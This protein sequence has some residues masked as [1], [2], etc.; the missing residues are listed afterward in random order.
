MKDQNVT[1]HTISAQ[2]YSVGGT[3]FISA[4]RQ[5]NFRDLEVKDNANNSTI[6]LSG[7]TSGVSGGDIS[8]TGTLST[9]TIS[10]KTS[11]S[12]VTIDS[13]LLKDGDISAGSLTLTGDLSISGTTTTINSTTVAVADSMFKYAKDNT[14]NN[15][16]IGFY[17]Q[18]V[19]SSTTKYSG[20]YYSASDSK[21]HIFKDQQA[22]PTTTVNTSGTGYTKGDLV[23]GNIDITTL[24][25]NSSTGN[26]GQIL[27]STG[28]GLSWIDSNTASQWTTSSNDIYYNTGNVGIGDSSPSYKLDV[29]GD[30]NLTGSL[31]INGVVQ[32]FGGGGTGD[33]TTS[34]ITGASNS[35][36]KIKENST[37]GWEIH[38]NYGS[39]AGSHSRFALQFKMIVILQVTIH[40]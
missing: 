17:G 16:D 22:E 5:G 34:L 10:E 3:N 31:R 40:I 36:N 1:A 32:T 9:D 23:C 8:I 4:S 2:N 33:I 21:F 39:T 37:Y 27:S 13:V 28:S 7:G 24:T 35:N 6:L 11:G 26:S 12:G 30:I 14:T 20:M 19:D 38:A 29:T 15:L 18:Y 25:A